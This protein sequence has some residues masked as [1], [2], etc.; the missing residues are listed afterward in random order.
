MDDESGETMAGF[1]RE[2]HSF[3]IRIWKEPTGNA[4][5]WRGW[6]NHVQTGQ[7][8]YFRDPV[9][10]SSIVANYLHDQHEAVEGL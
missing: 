6:I 10:I 7:R 9:A 8:H 5:Q 1:D 3:V 4:G 2:A